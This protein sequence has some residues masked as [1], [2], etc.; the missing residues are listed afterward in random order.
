MVGPGLC[1]L[2]DH[3]LNT[4]PFSPVVRAH[5]WWLQ[6]SCHLGSNAER[7]SLNVFRWSSL[8]A[9]KAA[10]DDISDGFSNHSWSAWR[11][12][13]DAIIISVTSAGNGGQTLTG[14]WKGISVNSPDSVLTLVLVFFFVLDLKHWMLINRCSCAMKWIVCSGWRWVVIWL[15]NKYDNKVSA[16]IEIWEEFRLGTCFVLKATDCEIWSIV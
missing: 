11:F 16:D 5:A 9:W 2:V 13:P 6:S 7:S 4:E 10:H 8:W 14:N 15:Q 12:V 1:R 3:D